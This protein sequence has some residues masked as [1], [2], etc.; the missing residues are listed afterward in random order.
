MHTWSRF[1]NKSAPAACNDSS[2]ANDCAKLYNRET[3]KLHK[4]RI[5]SQDNQNKPNKQRYE[6]NDNNDDTRKIKTNKSKANSK[7]DKKLYLDTRNDRKFQSISPSCTIAFSVFTVPVSIL[8]TTTKSDKKIAEQ[9]K[10]G[11]IDLKEQ[12]MT[13]HLTK[14]PAAVN[15]ARSSE[16]NTNTPHVRASADAFCEKKNKKL[17]IK[18]ITKPASIRARNNINNRSPTQLNALV[19]NAPA[20]TAV[21]DAV[22]TRLAGNAPRWTATTLAA[23]HWRRSHAPRSYTQTYIHTYTQREPHTHCPL[24]QTH[25]LKTMEKR[26]QQQKPNMNR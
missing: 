15:S 22:W 8:H 2:A 13:P 21:T 26:L 12:R 7:S 9:Q 23:A 24:V 10:R 6:K 5:I 18:T 14:L 1:F 17:S 16:Q 11:K 19:A 25:K 20:L 3:N 4:S